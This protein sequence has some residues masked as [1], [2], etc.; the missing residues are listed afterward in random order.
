MLTKLGAL[1]VADF[2]QISTLLFAS[3]LATISDEIIQLKEQIERH[4]KEL[5]LL[6]KEKDEIRSQ[7]ER[8]NERT[9]KWRDFTYRLQNGALCQDLWI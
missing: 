7:N 6:K 1:N 9:M 2:I 3:H 4:V 5:D 8:S